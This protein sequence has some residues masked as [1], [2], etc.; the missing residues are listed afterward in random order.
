MGLGKV[1]DKGM[2]VNAGAAGRGVQ[3][4]KSRNV[5]SDPV[6]ALRRPPA[7]VGQA[8]SQLVAQGSARRL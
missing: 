6:A 2:K 7:T 4:S 1:R 8:F 5:Q 3:T